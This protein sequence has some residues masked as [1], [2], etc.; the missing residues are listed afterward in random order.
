MDENKVEYAGREI[1]VITSGIC[2]SYVK[3][4]LPDASVLKLGMVYPLPKGKIKEFAANVKKLYVIEEL[5]PL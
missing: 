2:Y 4:A 5:E 1:G 3:E